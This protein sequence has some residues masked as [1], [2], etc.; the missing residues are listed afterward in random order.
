MDHAASDY[1]ALKNRSF[2]DDVVLRIIF[3]GM[4]E[5]SNALVNKY[6]SADAPLLYF[7]LLIA[8]TAFFIYF[9][10]TIKQTPFVQDLRE[11]CAFDLA[12]NTTFAAA[13]FLPDPQLFRNLTPIR[14]V[15]I[16]AIYVAL[17]LRIFWPC[18]QTST[19]TYHNW[20]TFGPIGLWHKFRKLPWQHCPATDSQAAAAYIG[21]VVSGL[22]GYYLWQ[23]KIRQVD[24]LYSIGQ[25][26]ALIILA[27]TAPPRAKRWWQAHLARLEEDRAA[28]EAA[29]QA[30][31][32]AKEAAQRAAD[33]AAQ[34]AEQ[35]RRIITQQAQQSLEIEA[36][37]IAAEHHAELVQAE[38]MQL[39][40]QLANPPQ[41]EPPPLPPP[42]PALAMLD[43]EQAPFDAGFYLTLRAIQERSKYIGKSKEHA[44][45]C[46]FETLAP[47]AMDLGVKSKW[48]IKRD[49]PN[50]KQLENC[51]MAGLVGFEEESKA[52][53]Q[54]QSA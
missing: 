31:D 14:D 16:K 34:E 8:P 38:A 40:E 11:F 44:K 54:K 1:A 9:F 33:A 28:K 20:P 23:H 41:A 26:T 6:A 35:A 32:A 2:D 39:R 51:I 13:F 50:R 43:P 49:Q 45:N 52:A 15:A 27:K 37:R 21:I 10:A 29:Q 53:S 47:V 30:A 7:P 5:L 12:L 17:W 42:H 18:Q 4:N 36:A 3:V 25:F 22:V 19:E 24:I 46:I 48:R